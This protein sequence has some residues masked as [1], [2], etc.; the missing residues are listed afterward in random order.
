[1]CSMA[2]NRSDMRSESVGF[3]MVGFVLFGTSLVVLE[4]ESY[5]TASISDIIVDISSH[6]RHT[7]I[8]LWEGRS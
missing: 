6:M 2:G 1:M 5:L 8:V 4:P 7:V 3:M